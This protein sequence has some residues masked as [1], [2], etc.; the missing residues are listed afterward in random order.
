MKA[1]MVFCDVFGT[2]FMQATGVFESSKVLAAPPV[3]ADV[4]DDYG[5]QHV[6]KA[7]EACK[8]QPYRLIA[9]R[10]PSFCWVDPAVKVVSD[11]KNW[12]PVEDMWIETA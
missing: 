6:E 12:T 11:G 3:E 1:V 2:Q 10:T 8:G 5:P 4:V 7:I 9:V